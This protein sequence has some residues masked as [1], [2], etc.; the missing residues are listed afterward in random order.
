MAILRFFCNY[1]RK[2]QNEDTAEVVIMLW[3]S[4]EVDKAD[5]GSLMSLFVWCLVRSV[6]AYVIAQ[7]RRK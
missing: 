5:Q 7:G 2:E 6:I 4:T 3:F 1:R